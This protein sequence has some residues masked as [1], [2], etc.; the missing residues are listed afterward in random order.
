MLLGYMVCEFRVRI[1]RVA[2]SKPTAGAVA[3]RKVWFANRLSRTIYMYF[4]II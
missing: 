1:I 3:V 2:N 4:T